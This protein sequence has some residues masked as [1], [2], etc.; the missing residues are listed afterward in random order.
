MSIFAAKILLLEKTSDWYFFSKIRG[1]WYMMLQQTLGGSLFEFKLKGFF[2][3]F[4][5]GVVVT[6]SPMCVFESA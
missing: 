1:K 3:Y 2:K 4:R 6:L 5:R